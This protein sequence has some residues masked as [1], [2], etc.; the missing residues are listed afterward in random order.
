MS[1]KLLMLLTAM[2]TLSVTLIAAPI[3]KDVTA[4]LDPTITFNLNGEQVMKDSNALMYNDTLYL[5]VRAI[6]TELGAEINYKDKVVYIETEETTM[7]EVRTKGSESVE[8]TET[9]PAL[10]AVRIESATLKD[11]D[12]DGTQLTILPAGKEDIAANMIILNLSEE[13]TITVDGKE[14]TLADLSLGME[15]SVSH[16]QMMTRSLPPQTPAFT[17][18]AKT[19]TEGETLPE[20]ITLEDVQVVEVNKTNFGYQVTV[21][22]NEN[23]ENP[24][25]QTILNVND[26]TLIHHEKNKMIYKAEDLEKGMK[27]TVKHSPI[28]TLS[29]PG[30]TTAFEITIL[31]Q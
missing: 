5:P 4:K 7:N 26:D 9:T 6:G 27:V 19:T 20:S 25:N 24:E 1:K 10:E 16:S 23:P 14:A 12:A 11:I 28:M 21:G 31:A 8:A 29:L 18:E 13:T 3:V 15:L 22:K 17:V 2:G 30:Q